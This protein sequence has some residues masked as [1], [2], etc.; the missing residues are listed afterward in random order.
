MKNYRNITF[1]KFVSQDKFRQI[2]CK[3]QEIKDSITTFITIAKLMLKTNEF[4]TDN[5]SQQNTSIVDQIYK[6]PPSLLFL[7]MPPRKNF[8]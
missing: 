7:T 3:V 2:Y 5:A 6:N 8:I 1:I 4:T